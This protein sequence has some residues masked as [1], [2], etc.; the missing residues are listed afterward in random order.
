MNFIEFHRKQ[1]TT[2]IVRSVYRFLSDGD[3]GFSSTAVRSPRTVYLLNK[4]IVKLFFSLSGKTYDV[5]KIIDFSIQVI[6]FK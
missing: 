5:C 4:K 2:Y 3:A 1:H 6:K